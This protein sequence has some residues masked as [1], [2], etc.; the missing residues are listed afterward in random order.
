[1]LMSI[2]LLS[3]AGRLLSPRALRRPSRISELCRA[4]ETSIVNRVGL[5]AIFQ[6]SSRLSNRGNRR[7]LMHAQ[8]MFSR[9]PGGI[10]CLQQGFWLKIM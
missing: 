6:R 2:T 7:N 9:R 3:C 8:C 1:M 5:Q 4:I 10:I